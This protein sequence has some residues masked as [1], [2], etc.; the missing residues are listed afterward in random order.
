MPKRFFALELTFLD[1]GVN[2]LYAEVEEL[3]GDMHLRSYGEYNDLSQFFEQT[4]SIPTLLMI[5]GRKVLSRE[6]ELDA[7]VRPE[8]VFPNI[9][10]SRILWQVDETRNHKFLSL[11]RREQVEQLIL[12]WPE[13][14]MLLDVQIGHQFLSPFLDTVLE[15]DILLGQF[16]YIKQDA[17]FYD[18]ENEGTISFLEEDIPVKIG[19]V[20]A[21]ALQF[22]SQKQFDKGYPELLE[23]RQKYRY[24]HYSE[25]ILKYGFSSILGLLLISFLVFSHYNEANRPLRFRVESNEN[26]INKLEDLEA[27][28]NRSQA[29][30]A[31]NQPS[32]SNY[33]FRIDQLLMLI[34]NSI[35]LNGIKVN[36]IIRIKKKQGELELE[37]WIIEI[38][39]STPNYDAF[40]SWLSGIKGL[41]WVKNYTIENY[42]EVSSNHEASFII[43]ISVKH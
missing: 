5:T 15:K 3:R 42:Q 4:K 28:F 37:N 22:L 36:P 6:L 7:Q 39:G 32:G 9:D 26:L 29:F 11:I 2:I 27:R 35:S 41:N 16:K 13:S 20:F 33:A 31:Q 14:K 23:F 21:Y 18:A 38:Q 40:Q 43:R 8:Q 17:K 1:G 30:I 12:G 19:L 25:L 34:P 24:K 10:P